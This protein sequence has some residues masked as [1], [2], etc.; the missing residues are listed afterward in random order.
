VKIPR[1]QLENTPAFST[2]YLAKITRDYR[3]E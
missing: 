3:V 1:S 2:F